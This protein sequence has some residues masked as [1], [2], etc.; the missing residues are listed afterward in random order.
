[1]ASPLFWPHFAAT[2]TS[3]AP[4]VALTYVD[5]APDV[6]FADPVAFTAC[7]LAVFVMSA[8]GPPALSV[9]ALMASVWLVH[10]LALRMIRTDDHKRVKITQTRAGESHVCGNVKQTHRLRLPVPV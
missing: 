9:A 6:L 7:L 10:S 1:M 5:F 3:A 2:L 8:S 4:F